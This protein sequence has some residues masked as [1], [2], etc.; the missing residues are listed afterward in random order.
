MSVNE[1]IRVSQ[2]VTAFISL[3]I[4]RCKIFNSV[5]FEPLLLISF[6]GWNQ[7]SRDAQTGQDHSV[8]DGQLLP[9]PGKIT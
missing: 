3:I 6:S 2:S 8:G 1:P 4:L 5:G 7:K 9:S